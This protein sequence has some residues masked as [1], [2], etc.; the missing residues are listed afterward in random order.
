MEPPK[1]RNSVMTPPEHLKAAGKYLWTAT[2]DEWAL[3]DSALIV[4][5]TSCQCADRLTEIREALD[6]DGIMITDP[7][8]RQRSHPLLAAESQV[9]GILLRAWN[10]LSL[11]DDEPP[12]IGRPVT[13]R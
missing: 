3:E 12:K 6:R 10:Q 8:G 13:R 2:M 4:L 1:F 7:S 5:A 9:H 11:D